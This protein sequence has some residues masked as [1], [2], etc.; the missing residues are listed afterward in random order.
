[1]ERVNADQIRVQYDKHDFQV[2]VFRSSPKVFR[3][4]S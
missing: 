3:G 4:I 2:T 1:M